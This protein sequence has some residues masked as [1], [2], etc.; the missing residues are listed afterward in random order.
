MISEKYR[1]K[2]AFS[3]ILIIVF[4]LCLLSLTGCKVKMKDTK[5]IILT[6]NYK[7]DIIAVNT[8]TNTS[9]VLL[10]SKRWTSYEA[11]LWINDSVFCMETE[12]KFYEEDFTCF[13]VKNG[14]IKHLETR[15]IIPNCFG[16]KL[17]DCFSD[18]EILIQTKRYEKTGKYNYNHYSILTVLNVEDESYYDL[19]NTDSL[20]SESYDFY[21]PKDFSV[22]KEKNLIY[23]K[24]YDTIAVKEARKKIQNLRR[25]ASKYSNRGGWAELFTALYNTYYDEKK[26]EVFKLLSDLFSNEIDVF[27]ELSDLIF[28][29]YSSIY[30]YN[31]ENQEITKL[32]TFPWYSEP[33]TISPDG[34]NIVFTLSKDHNLD[35]YL[36]DIKTKEIKRLTTNS[37]ADFAPEYSPDGQEIAFISDSTG[38]EQIWIMDSSGKN[39]R[40]V[41]DIAGGVREPLSWNPKQ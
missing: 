3:H 9:K 28:R 36:M 31:V 34:K 6:R 12:N 38:S 18:K 11:P 25:I 41:T 37:K 19:I 14:K 32:K 10:R 27:D 2:N 22:S 33:P 20:P 7:G 39:L 13:D 16:S 26:K 15:K 21:G 1:S 17:L 29:L 40:K 30:V 4:A 8:T 35:I 5:D 23:F 24:G